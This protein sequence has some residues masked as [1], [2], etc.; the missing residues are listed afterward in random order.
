LITDWL[1]IYARELDNVRV[2]IDWA[3]SVEE[4]APIAVELCADSIAMMF[5]LSLVGEGRRRA[6][7]A[8]SAIDA[9]VR[10]P[11]RR[12]MQVLAV[13]QATRIYT[14]GPSDFG[15]EAWNR[16]LTIATE[17]DDLDY[18]VR[19]LWGLW[20]DNLYGGRPMLS[21]TFARQFQELTATLSDTVMSRTGTVLGP[22]LIGTALHYCGDQNAAR[23]HLEHVLSHYVRSDHRWKVLGSRLD[24]ATVTRATLSRV[25]WLQGYPDQALGQA[26]MAMQDAVA[27]DHLM[28]ILYVLVEAIIPISLFAGDLTSARRFHGT[29]LEQAPRA[30]FRIWQ[31]FGRCFQAVL[32]VNE[33]DQT[34]GLPRLVEA[35]QELEETGFCTHLTM[36]LG[37]LAQ[38]QLRADAGAEALQTVNRALDRCDSHREG[39]FT[40][41]LLRI[42]SDVLLRSGEEQQATDHLWR[43][44]G[45]S[46][47]QGARLRELRAATGL[48]RLLLRQGQGVQA[49]TVLA[50][51]YDWF[52]EGFEI[53]DLRAA[54][55]VM[56][57][58]P[59]G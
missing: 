44:L 13:L 9:G 41:E 53:A 20:N 4:Y 38:T 57:L 16:V 35:I 15:R 59:E 29:L 12:E 40:S 18:Q 37:I 27:D 3:F 48:T 26:N 36:F 39:W 34:T 55:E 14:D 58:L 32:Q 51:V 22:R 49:R 52:T 10:V 24:H 56:Q 6:E 1:A 46:R 7:Q 50:P 30:G 31:T 43:A 17:F 47:Q 25:L 2:A 5:D 21:L 54:R 28:S 19:A 11:P 23:P 42:K 45:L 8:L 33:D